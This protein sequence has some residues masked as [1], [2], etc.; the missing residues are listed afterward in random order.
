MEENHSTSSEIPEFD[1][2][3]HRQLAIDEYQLIRGNYEDFS[4]KIKNIIVEALRV[5]KI[6]IHSIENRAKSIDSFGNKSAKPSDINPNKPKYTEP[7]KQIT[8]LA[9]VRIITF[10]L[11]VVDQVEE[12]IKAEF[13]IQEKTDKTALLVEEEKL[14]YQSIHYLVKLH[15]KRIELPE[16][17]RF[18]GLVAEIQLRTILQHS[19]AEIEHDI[20]YKSVETIPILIKRRFMALAGLLEIA[21]REFQAI[22]DED[23]RLRVKARESVKEGNL[24]QVEITP[25]ALKAYLDNKLGSD[26]RMRQFS[27]EWNARLL[28]KLGFTNFRQI[29]E[30]I[31]TY[32]DDQIS[33]IA[34]GARRGQLTR[35]ET[36]LVAG[37]GESLIDKHIFN[38]QEWFKKSILRQLNAL[39]ESGITIGNYCPE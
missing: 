7:L 8:D 19:W 18:Q 20:Q 28:H 26:G 21:D 9:A 36:L 37:M 39:R 35:F 15:H 30:C 14:G 32:D 6:N 34:W 2:A 11:N 16:Y 4:Q 1:F 25:D 3:K 10:F 22:Q 29:D 13:D 31:K 23:E 5:K 38:S 12:I 24:E 33:K 27:Y 17:S